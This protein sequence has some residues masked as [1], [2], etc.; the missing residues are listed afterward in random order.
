[1]KHKRHLVN[2][3]KRIRKEK[4]MSI[5]RCQRMRS[6]TL[7]I[8]ILR[9]FIQLAQCDCLL[10]ISLFAFINSLQDKSTE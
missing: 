3:N 6:I 2:L 4:L 8:L 7:R 9:P 1:M 10:L 5:L